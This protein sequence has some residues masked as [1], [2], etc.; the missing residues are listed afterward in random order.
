MRTMLRRVTAKKGEFDGQPFDYCRIE[1][2]I[3]VMEGQKGDYGVS[4]ETLLFGVAD[5]ERQLAHLR[6]H[7]PLLVDVDFEMRRKGKE[8]LV[9]VV[10]AFAVVQEPKQ[11]QQ[12]QPAS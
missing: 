8:G 5:D 9:N 6:G 12:Q 1:I 7:L 3:P 2:D 10:T 11:K 4:T